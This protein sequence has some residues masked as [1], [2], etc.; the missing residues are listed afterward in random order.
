MDVAAEGAAAVEGVARTP[1]K[2]EAKAAKPK[3]ATRLSGKTPATEVAGFRGLKGASTLL[4]G[5]A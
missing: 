5:R 4:I 1:K 2:E 3:K